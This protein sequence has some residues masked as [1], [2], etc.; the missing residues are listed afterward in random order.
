L[1]LLN[2]EENLKPK[3]F[4]TLADLE[5]C[6]TGSFRG[7]SIA[8]T[9]MFGIVFVQE[10]V[11]GFA[12]QVR[13]RLPYLNAR[14]GNDIDFIWTGW[15]NLVVINGYWSPTSRPGGSEDIDTWTFDHV[16]FVAYR[17]NVYMMQ[18]VLTSPKRACNRRRFHPCTKSTTTPIHRDGARTGEMFDCSQ[19]LARRAIGLRITRAFKATLNKALDSSI[20]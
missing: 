11:E 9:K 16:A 7:A 15:D 2:Q 10:H 12:K 20:Q 5:A 18:T 19:L 4:H 13:M 3:T 6:V 8:S 1:R 14:S 17:Q